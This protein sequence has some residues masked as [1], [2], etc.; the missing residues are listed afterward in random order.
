MCQGFGQLLEAGETL[1]RAGALG[2]DTE[3]VEADGFAEW[4][5]LANDY[6]VTLL[7]AEAGRDVGRRVGMP[8]LISAQCLGE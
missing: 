1:L 6:I 2:D 5:A 3:H 8:L 7:A 4:P